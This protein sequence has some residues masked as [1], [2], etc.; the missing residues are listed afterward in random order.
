MDETEQNQYLLWAKLDRFSRK[1]REAERN[2]AKGFDYMEKPYIS[3]SFGKDSLVMADIILNRYPSTPLMYVNCG[4]YDE[5]PD[6]LRVKEAFLERHAGIEFIELGG[7][8]IWEYYQRVGLYIQDEET[9]REARIAQREYAESLGKVLD[10]E[11]KK[12]GFDGT[13]IGMRSEESYIRSRLFAMR[14]EIY[15][16]SVREQ[17]VCCPL[18]RWNGKDIWAY[19]V[20]A[21]LPYNELYDMAPE[22]R[23][24]A[25]NGA[26]FGTRSMRYGRLVFLKRMY[27]D[28]FNEFAA[29]FPEVRAYI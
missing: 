7:P 11:A 8:S 21:N 5:W 28:L 27:P 1:I 17:W 18:A 19:I 22:G 13:F 25:R 12:R 23:E 4:K 29:E 15:F 14:G 20:S 9:T 2:I 6:T 16:A 10:R 26:M 24:L 3:M